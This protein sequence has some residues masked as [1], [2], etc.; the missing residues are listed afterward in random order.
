MRALLREIN[1]RQE[2]RPSIV[3]WAHPTSHTAI[4]QAIGFVE[5]NLPGQQVQPYIE[6]KPVNDRRSCFLLADLWARVVPVILAAT[7]RFIPPDS[8]ENQD[9]LRVGEG[10]FNLIANIPSLEYRAA[11]AQHSARRAK[12][13]AKGIEILLPVFSPQHRGCRM[14]LSEC[15]NILDGLWKLQCSVSKDMQHVR[16]PQRTH[17]QVAH[18][19]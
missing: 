6:V 11:P 19:R 1:A 5:A 17:D 18:H 14:S 10:A 3:V 16:A 13:F 4:A 8:I 2:L 12:Q 9:L 15:G 7:R